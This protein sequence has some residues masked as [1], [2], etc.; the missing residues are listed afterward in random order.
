MYLC[1]IDLI[2]NNE[3]PNIIK[4]L[5]LVTIKGYVLNFVEKNNHMMASNNEDQ[6][7]QLVS[8]CGVDREVAAN[9]LEACGGN[10]EM[11]VDM[12]MED[13]GGQDFLSFFLLIKHS[14]H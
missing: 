9:L 1:E 5:L 11:A 13:V 8:I 2:E 10:M 3:L 14:S 12:H 7:D 6:V 4:Y